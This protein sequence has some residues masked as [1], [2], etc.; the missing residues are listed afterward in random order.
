MKVCGDQA[1]AL[2][3]FEAW[4]RKVREAV[5]PGQLLVFETGKDGFEELT[6][7]LGVTA[8]AGA[9]YTHANSAAEFAF[10]INIQRALALATV[11]TVAWPC[12]SPS[13]ASR[14]RAQLGRSGRSKCDFI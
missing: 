2:A 1:Y 7:F 11:L 4:T 3:F 5:P 9:P 13:A 10:G 6:R 14:G 8:P 12:G